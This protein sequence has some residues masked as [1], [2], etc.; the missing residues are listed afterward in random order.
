M[1][2]YLLFQDYFFLYTPM[3][4]STNRSISDLDVFLFNAKHNF[5]YDAINRIA[6][7]KS[8]VYNTTYV[9]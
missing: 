4:Y 7:T 8:L 3:E 5:V 6:W 2:A 9:L 1:H